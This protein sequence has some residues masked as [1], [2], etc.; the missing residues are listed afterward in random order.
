M[1][2]GAEHLEVLQ[3]VVCRIPVDMVNLHRQGLT[4]P[5]IPLPALF[6][7][8]QVLEG[9]DVTAAKAT[10][11]MAEEPGLEPGIVCFKGRCLTSLATPQREV[12]PGESLELSALGIRIP[13]TSPCAYPE[14]VC[15]LAYRVCGRCPRCCRSMPLDP[16]S[17]SV[18]SL[19]DVWPLLGLP[20]TVAIRFL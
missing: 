13:R 6:A 18:A 11:K 1:A 4:I 17:S 20:Y 12:D 3:P 10:N 2:V 5:L 8:R 15:S 19:W 16:P 9:S 14:W 7:P